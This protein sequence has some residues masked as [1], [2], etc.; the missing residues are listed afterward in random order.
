[1]GLGCETTRGKE[2]EYM[3][4]VVVVALES[5]VMVVSVEEVAREWE[6]VP[7]RGALV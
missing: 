3:V 4:L 6:R 1:V 5:V 2:E 7:L